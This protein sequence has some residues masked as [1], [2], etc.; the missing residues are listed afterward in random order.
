MTLDINGYN[1]VFKSFVEF[2]QQ[3][4][5]ANDSKAVVDAHV[6]RLGNR[7]ILAVT[8]S[9]TDEVHKWL[10][11]NDEYAVNDRTRNLFKKAIIENG[12]GYDS[13]DDRLSG[14]PNQLNIRSMYSDIDLDANDMETEFQAA[15]DDLLWFADQYLANK[16]H[17]NY[18]DTNVDFIFNRDILISET[19]VIEDIKNSVGILSRRTLVEQHPYID[20]VE[21]EMQR[22][23]EEEQ[24]EMQEYRVTSKD[25]SRFFA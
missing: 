25:S 24:A 9:L 21:E 8:Q 23:E 10:R 19:Q 2:A 6:N 16:L 12:M 20:D 22:I 3:R 14:N 4:V 5:D 7:K 15:L 1:N 18:F 11:T 17:K 13:K